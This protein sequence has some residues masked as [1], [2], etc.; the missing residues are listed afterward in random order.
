M[1][2]I[3]STKPFVNLKSVLWAKTLETEKMGLIFY[4]YFDQLT[5]ANKCTNHIKNVNFNCIETFV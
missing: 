2:M 1:C 5:N 4:C 3:T